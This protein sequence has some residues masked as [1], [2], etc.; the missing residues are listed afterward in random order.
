[1]SCAYDRSNLTSI[2]VL[3]YVKTCL[4]N[5]RDN[6]YHS[7]RC[8]SRISRKKQP[9]LRNS[10][11]SSSH[12]T[13]QLYKQFLLDAHWMLNK[14]LCLEC[15]AQFSW[16]NTKEGHITIFNLFKTRFISVI[17]YMAIETPRKFDSVRVLRNSSNAYSLPRDAAHKVYWKIWKPFTATHIYHY[18]SRKRHRRWKCL[19]KWMSDYLPIF[20][21]VSF[22]QFSVSANEISNV[23]KYFFSCRR[24]FTAYSP[25][26]WPIWPKLTA[27]RSFSLS[28]RASSSTLV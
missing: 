23:I 26:F 6:V 7:D 12:Q 1:M 4:L 10:F 8:D 22:R 19:K 27:E 17:V 3:V 28:E 13:S 14:Y 2:D 21:R 5:Y 15:V 18:V 25:V 16:S 11:I 20:V 9:G 24:I